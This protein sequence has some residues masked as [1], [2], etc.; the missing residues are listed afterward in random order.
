MQYLKTTDCIFVDEEV[1]VLAFDFALSWNWW[2][3]YR[4]LGMPFWIGSFT[5]LAARLVA[6]A[7]KLC[8]GAKYDWIDYARPLQEVFV[9]IA[10][11]YLV[12]FG[13]CL[14]IIPRSRKAWAIAF[15]IFNAC[16]FGWLPCYKPHR[17]V[18]GGLRSMHVTV[19]RDGIKFVK[20]SRASISC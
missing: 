18:F 10:L 20:E 8:S 5:S 17:P 15:N 6:M 7:V 13:I 3:V 1:A 4:K 11:G 9:S 19:A 14:L 12:F 2:K 16:L